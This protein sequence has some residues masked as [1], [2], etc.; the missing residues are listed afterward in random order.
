[1]YPGVVGMHVEDVMADPELG[2]N[3]LFLTLK[4]HDSWF[5]LSST[6]LIV[7]KL[8][9]AAAYVW[10]TSTAL[11]KLSILYL[12]V[13]I[14]KNR[15]F[16]IAAASI[17]SLLVVFWFG[18]IIVAITQCRPIAKNW[19]ILLPGTC[20]SSLNIQLGTATLN[21]IFDLAIVILPMPVL[22]KLQMAFRK[23]LLVTGVLSLGLW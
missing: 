21:M 17:G 4:V 22:W 1:M 13:G 20:A 10:I 11:T 3:A 8:Y 9:Y 5:R 15:S 14:F 23:K 19:N 18:D 7:F 6:S 16:Y 12:Y 2:L